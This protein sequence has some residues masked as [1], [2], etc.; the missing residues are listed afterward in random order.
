MITFWFLVAFEKF[1]RE[2]YA[3]TLQ[4]ILSVWQ[5]VFFLWWIIF[6]T[7]SLRLVKN[8]HGN[9]QL[10]QWNWKTTNLLQIAIF[11]SSFICG[12]ISNTSWSWRILFAENVGN[13]WNY[14]RNRP[15]SSKYDY[16]RLPPLFLTINPC[17]L[18]W[19][20]CANFFKIKVAVFRPLYFRNGVSD[21]NFFF[22][23]NPLSSCTFKIYQLENFR[24]IHALQN[25][26]N[27]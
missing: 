19:I 7:D 3:A 10:F 24:A 11:G 20:K 15:T 21:P 5:P 12:L 18:C 8:F 25:Y 2:E 22:A 27:E 6:T 1:V 17:R 13:R 4:N 14:L 9:F 26:E 23:S 16:D